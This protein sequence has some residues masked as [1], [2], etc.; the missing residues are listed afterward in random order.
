MA[1]ISG[2]DFLQLAA[3]RVLLTAYADS[4]AAIDAINKIKLHHYLMKPREPPGRSLFPVLSDLLDDWS[5]AYVPEF[6]GLVRADSLSKSMSHYLV[7]RIREIPTIA[8]AGHCELVAVAGETQLAEITIRN[9]LT[10]A[11]ETRPARGVFIFIGAEPTTDWLKGTVLGDANGFLRTG[12]GTFCDG[13]RP[14]DWTAG[15]DAYLLE[16]SMPGVFAIGDVRDVAIRRVANSVSEGSIVLYF[17]RQYMRNRWLKC[18]FLIEP[19]SPPPNSPRCP[20]SPKTPARSTDWP[21]ISR[22]STW[23]VANA[24]PAKATPPTGSWSSLK[25]RSTTVVSMIHMARPSF[26]KKGSR[27]ACCPCQE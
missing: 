20:Y 15:R 11:T 22:P 25:A 3:R 18:H 2:V 4:N 14:P 10:G 12:A 9:T 13:K 6:D 5:A 1:Q 7:E 19:R 17:I 23:S 27:P 21:H 8:V 16:T 26:A 24:L